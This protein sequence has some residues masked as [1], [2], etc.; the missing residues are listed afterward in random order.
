MQ[1][2]EN[3]LPEKPQ[4]PVPPQTESPPPVDRLV[5]KDDGNGNGNGKKL[6]TK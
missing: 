4:Q 3:E 6:E 5:R 2:N 1:S